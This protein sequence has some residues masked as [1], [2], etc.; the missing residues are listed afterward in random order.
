MNNIL[1]AGANGM[2]GSFL[3][4]MFNTN[5]TITA[6]DYSTESI[7]E[8][9]FPL[10]LTQEEDVE[11]FA[12]KFSKY[13]ALIFLVG[14]AHKKGKGKELDE[15]RR[16][17]KQ[18]LVNLLSSLNEVNKLPQ[19]IIF[20]STISVYGEKMNQNI[21]NEDSDKNPFSP[22][23]VTKLETEEY[24]LEHFLDK[25]W[26]LRF[27]PVY[28]P[29]FQLNINRRTKTAGRFYKVGTG[30]KKLSLCNLENIGSVV[31]GILEDK[32]PSGIYNISDEKK[33]SYND[34]LNY[35]N[36][37][38]VIPIPRILVKGLYYVGKVM[39]NIFLKENAIKLI[40]DN[41]FPSDKIRSFVDLPATLNDIKQAND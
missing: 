9:F 15:F 2:I 6:L 41:I 4:N 28:S 26:I 23:A 17:N 35:V 30:E 33:Y 36:A 37:K 18:T 24:L 22:Y 14:L 10:D 3:Y 29:D 1:L 16:V 12:K 40:S 19:K 7:E 31:Q 34:L 5:Y 27:A 39:N 8:N 13:D 32:V 11:N 20:A 21:Y 38:W 25:S